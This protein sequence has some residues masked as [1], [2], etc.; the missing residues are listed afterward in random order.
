MENSVAPYPHGAIGIHQNRCS[1]RDNSSGERTTRVNIEKKAFLPK[2]NV[3]T[4]S[5]SRLIIC[6]SK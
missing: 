4:E 1:P 5:L 3:G 6:M 2:K